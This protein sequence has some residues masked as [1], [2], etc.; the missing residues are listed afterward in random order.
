MKSMENLLAFARILGD[1][2]RQQM[3]QLMCCRELSVK[4][5][6]EELAEKHNKTLTQPTVSHHLA[7]MRELGI[8]KVRREGRHSFYELD[9]ERVMYCCGQ[10]MANFA[11]TIPLSTFENTD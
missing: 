11:P 4:Q 5:V 10:I 2:T 1:E 6:V 3:M 9:Q 8:V 7:E